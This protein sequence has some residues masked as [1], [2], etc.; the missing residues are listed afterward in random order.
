MIDATPRDPHAIVNYGT[1]YE[2]AAR[3]PSGESVVVGFTARNSKAGLIDVL[4]SRAD[5]LLALLDDSM[6]DDEEYPFER[7]AGLWTWRV[8]DWSIGFTGE[9]ERS[10]YWRNRA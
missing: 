1:R 5:E 2:V 6:D 9:T 4:R 7:E 10:V 3:H 8:N